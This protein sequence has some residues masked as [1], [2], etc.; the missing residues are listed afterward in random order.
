MGADRVETSN[1]TS[2]NSKKEIAN[3]IAKEPA[4]QTQQLRKICIE[5]QT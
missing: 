1:T 4:W 2:L 5:S 3:N